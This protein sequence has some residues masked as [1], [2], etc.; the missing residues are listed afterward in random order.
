[1]GLSSGNLLVASNGDLR[2]TSYLR[3]LCKGSSA[4]AYIHCLVKYTLISSSQLTKLTWLV[5]GQTPR[6]A[7]ASA[8]YWATF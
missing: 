8:K 5:P 2:F 7:A 1:M 3:C 6:V 4:I